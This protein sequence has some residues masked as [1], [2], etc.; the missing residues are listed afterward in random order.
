ML[1]ITWCLQASVANLEMKMQEDECNEVAELRRE[2]LEAR[3]TLK[4]EKL[5]T[6]VSH[7]G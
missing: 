1:T 5:E 3:E 4:R 6:Q 2:L 7:K